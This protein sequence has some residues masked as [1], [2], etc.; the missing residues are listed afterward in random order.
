MLNPNLEQARFFVAAAYYHHGYMEEALIEMEK[1]GACTA[2]MSI[3]P[4]RIEAL[5]ALFSGSFAP[6]RARLEEVSR[7]S[8]QAIGDTYL[9][10][11]YYYSG[12]IERGRDDAR[13]AGAPP[14]L[15]RRRGQARRWPAFWRRSAIP[16]RP[17]CRSIAC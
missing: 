5:V 13:I 15:R 12:S 16:P 7:L 8:S 11:A 9:A 2:S 17:A 1:G 6:A 3:E 14:L 4:I 10:L